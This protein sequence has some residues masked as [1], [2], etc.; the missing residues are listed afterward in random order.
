LFDWC[1]DFSDQAV[2]QT[3]SIPDHIVVGRDS[4]GNSLSKSLDIL[5]SHG[6]PNG[7]LDRKGGCAQLALRSHQIQPLLHV[8]GHGIDMTLTYIAS[9]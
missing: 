5:M 4:N 7:E 2:N 8:F 3:K 6:P 9:H 1:D